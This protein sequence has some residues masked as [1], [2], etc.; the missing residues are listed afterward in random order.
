MSNGAWRFL[1][2]VVILLSISN[3]F[4]DWPAEINSAYYTGSWTQ[5]YADI[6][7][8]IVVLQGAVSDT[9]IAADADIDC[10]KLVDSTWTSSKAVYGYPYFT[11]EPGDSAKKMAYGNAKIV[12]ADSAI[13][14][15]AKISVEINWSDSS[16]V[17]NP[18][19]AATPR[20]INVS[21]YCAIDTICWRN[22]SR[23]LTAH[24]TAPASRFPA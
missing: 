23:D 4:G 11:A 22:E 13:F 14:P 18:A 19:F 5:L 3:A 16:E 17:G 9:N 20:F 8:G 7:K 15:D 10:S 2:A 12:D 1:L 24:P 6:M 21:Y